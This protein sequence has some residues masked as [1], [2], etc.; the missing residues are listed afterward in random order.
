MGVISS[1][2]NET[3]SGTL[4]PSHFSQQLEKSTSLAETMKFYMAHRILWERT[5]TSTT[6]RV[7]DQSLACDVT[8]SLCCLSAAAFA[9]AEIKING[10]CWQPDISPTYVLYTHTQTHI[11]A[12]FIFKVDILACAHLKVYGSA[13]DHICWRPHSFDIQGRASMTGFSPDP[14]GIR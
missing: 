7:S 5:H 1:E 14:K 11:Q 3:L 13:T 6:R 2:E 9:Q 4:T 8:V 12:A 10:T